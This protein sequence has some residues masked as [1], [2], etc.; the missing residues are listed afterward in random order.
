MELACS[1]QCHHPSHPVHGPKHLHVEVNCQR[2]LRPWYLFLPIALS[3]FL[4]ILFK[5]KPLMD[6]VSKIY[7]WIAFP[8]WLF[9]LVKTKTLSGL[10]QSHIKLPFWYIFLPTTLA[11]LC[12]KYNINR[13]LC[14]IDS[15]IKLPIWYT[16]FATLAGLCIKY[17]VNIIK[18][19]E[20]DIKLP[21]WYLLPPT[22][23]AGL[24]PAVDWKRRR[25]RWPTS[26]AS[27][28]STWNANCEIASI[29][30]ITRIRFYKKMCCLLCEHNLVDWCYMAAHIPVINLVG[31]CYSIF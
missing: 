9:Y 12:I 5:H 19:I 16:Y 13:N 10:I 26:G 30:Q 27:S 7:C 14:H 28:R 17:Y 22:A 15:E 25:K 4:K 2:S 20:S 24:C 6:P 21:I 29:R 1:L 3:G 11:G 23:L 8:S 31:K 18:W